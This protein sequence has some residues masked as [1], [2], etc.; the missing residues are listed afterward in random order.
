MLFGRARAWPALPSPATHRLYFDHG[1]ETL[2][3]IYARY[4]ARVDRIVASRGYRQ[5][6][7]WLTRNFPGQAHNEESWASRVDVPLGFL[8]APR[9]PIRQ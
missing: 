7:N 3:K 8:L 4:Q 6:T 1:S 2:D 5:G 9:R